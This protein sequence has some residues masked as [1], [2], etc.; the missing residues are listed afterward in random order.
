MLFTTCFCEVANC[1]DTLCGRVESEE[2]CAGVNR[3]RAQ[4]V[5]NASIAGCGDRVV[6]IVRQIEP[7]VP[8]TCKQSFTGHSLPRRYSSF[9]EGRESKHQ[10]Q[11]EL[12]HAAARA[13]EDL[14]R[15]RVSETAVTRV[16]NRRRRVAEIKVIERVQ[17]ISS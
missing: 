3:F 17:A 6:A 5:V 2:L 12:N 11:P 13:A 9:A 10:F 8:G 4:H 15:T 14:A 1:F 16:G 7:G